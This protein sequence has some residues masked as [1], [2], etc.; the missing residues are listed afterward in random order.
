M[1]VIFGI[2]LGALLTVSI[3]FIVDS[4]N[5]R[6]APATTGSANAIVE[7]RPMV[8]WDVVDAN[9]RLAQERVREAFTR[10]SHKIS[11]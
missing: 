3:A 11:S 6:P 1:R 9:L 2:I 4:W 7:S 10:L 8:N 5:A